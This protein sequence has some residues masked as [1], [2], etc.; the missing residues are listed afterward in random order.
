MPYR[1]F[2]HGIVSDSL[3]VSASYGIGELNLDF[4]G[5]HGT[6]ILQGL[7]LL[8]VILRLC[9]DI[10]I[11][12]QA[13]KPLNQ[14]F[15]QQSPANPTTQ[16]SETRMGVR[17]ENLG[18]RKGVE[19]YAR[20]PPDTYDVDAGLRPA[21]NTTAEDQAPKQIIKE[22]EKNKDSDGDAG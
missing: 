18:V 9:R 2:S 19:E 1:I 20:R 6:Y 17:V 5:E 14:N 8:T 12:K 7:I 21:D 16:S 22:E 11:G 4:I 15:S 3:L 10:Y 13:N